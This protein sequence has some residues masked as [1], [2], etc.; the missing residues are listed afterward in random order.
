[1]LDDSVI[2]FRGPF[3]ELRGP[4]NIKNDMYYQL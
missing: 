3:A 1:M 4:P 2:R